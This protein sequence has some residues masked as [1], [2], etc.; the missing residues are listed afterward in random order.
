M[1][2]EYPIRCTSCGDILGDIMLDY[3]EKLK[4]IANNSKLSKQE[5]QDKKSELIN[6]YHLQKYWCCCSYLITYTPL[7]DYMF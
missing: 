7:N 3:V 2:F 4:K 1:V 5:K 6:S